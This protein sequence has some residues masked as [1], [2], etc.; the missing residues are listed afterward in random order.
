MTTSFLE[1]TIIDEQQVRPGTTH[2]ERYSSSKEEK[3]TRA[4]MKNEFDRRVSGGISG[5]GTNNGGNKREKKGKQTSSSLVILD[6]TNY[7]KGYRYEL[8]CI[9]R[10]AGTRHGVVWVL[11]DPSVCIRWNEERKKKRI[12]EKMTKRKSLVAGESE[13]DKNQNSGEGEDNGQERDCDISEDDGY[14]P[15][16]VEMEELM[17][18]YEPPDPRNRW[19]RPLYRVDMSSS[20]MDTI[21]E[22][23]TI[24]ASFFPKIRVVIV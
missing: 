16:S 7:I 22:N 24:V 12:I 15:T 4:A 9:S 23:K 1:V 6:A 17:G 21:A 20:S 10:A 14:Y 5:G 8:H 13:V 18:R 3:I 2:K 11:N 19:D